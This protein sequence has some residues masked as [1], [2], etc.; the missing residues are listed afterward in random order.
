MFSVPKGP[1][2]V[3]MFLFPKAPFLVTDFGKIIKIEIFCLISSKN[4]QNFIKKFPTIWASR[5]NAR[6][7]NAFFVK[8][9]KNMLK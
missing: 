4:Y 6:K 2:L 8:I 7:S 5:S 9:S 3:T 1:F